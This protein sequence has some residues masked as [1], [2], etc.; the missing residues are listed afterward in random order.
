MMLSDAETW[1]R[2]LDELSPGIHPVD[3]VATRVWFRFFPLRLAEAV[4]GTTDLAVLERTL[5]LEGRYRLADQVDSSHWFLYGH[6]YW[7]AVTA[8]MASTDVGGAVPIVSVVR[9]LASQAADA[10]RADVSLLV[11]ISA[12]AVMTRQQVGNRAFGLPV[13]QGAG[14]SR[15]LKSP[16][17]I[18]SS[19]TVDDAQGVFGIFRG[20]RRRYSVWFDERRSDGRF[21][22]VNQQ[23]LTTAAAADL[24][25][26]PYDRGY[27]QH[28]AIPAQCRS[29][30]CGTCWIGVLGGAERLSEVERLEARRLKECGYL[31]DAEGTPHIRLACMARA[32]GNVTIVIPPWNGFIGRR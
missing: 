10:V 9:E 26:Y 1:A 6:R 14:V 3:R 29:G 27:S 17:E 24:R 32:A 20:D 19:R 25:E 13:Q 16:D 5:R 28:G 12:V 23:H 8:L 22:I 31:D 4:A 18:C 21:P 2:A 11:G 7:D 30:S 15:L